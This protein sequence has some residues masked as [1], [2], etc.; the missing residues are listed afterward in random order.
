M[1][2]PLNAAQAILARGL[3]VPGKTALIADGEPVSFG[4]LADLARRCAG[5]CVALGMEL[6]DTVGI[7][8]HDSPLACAS[9]LGTVLAGGT[10]VPMNPRLSAADYAHLASGARMRLILAEDEYLTLLGQIAETRVISRG[11]F[12]AGVR[13]APTAGS[14]APTE[15][16]D[17]AFWLF[18]SGTTGRPKGIVHSQA[19]LANS[20]KMLR[21]AVGAT[22]DSV[23]LC[24]SKYFFAFGLDNGLLGPLSLGAT[25]II[26]SS[27]PDAQRVLELAAR[28]RPDCLFTV[29]T[30]YRRLLAQGRPALAPLSKIA[31]HYT[32]G[33]R[34]PGVLTE[35]WHSA[36]GA[37]LHVCYGMSETYTNAIANFH[38]GNRRGTM[39]RLLG[40]VQARRLDADGRPAAPGEPG[41]L[42]LRHPDIALR[43]SD[44][45]ANQA[46]FS[47]GW[48]RTGDLCTRDA[49][50]FFRHEGRADELIKVAGQWVK[51]GEVEEAALGD[52]RVLEA[53]CVVIADQDGFERLALFVVPESQGAGVAAARARCDALASHCRP[54]WIYEIAE[55]PRTATGKIQRFKLK[56]QVPAGER[57]R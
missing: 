21:E 4:E 24:T 45:A 40:Q 37:E 35:Q 28:F 38:G 48:F 22:G 42:W 13:R 2:G 14:A 23:V 52:P 39:G 20:G 54:K 31:R 19:S 18:S 29:P 5:A 17:P 51:P 46:A 15:A 53:A 26:D 36:T 10:A 56:E 41:V 7:M 57:A 33:E 16:A 32:G 43:Y 47:D 8:L 25:A 27:W 9:L 30:F 44:D 50:G 12:E 34:V 11:E 55:I 1:P 6:G 3:A 49:A